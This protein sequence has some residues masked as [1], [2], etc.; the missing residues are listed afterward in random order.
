VH[1]GA[2]VVDADAIIGAKGKHTG[3]WRQP[4]QL[5]L[6]P[7]IERHFDIH[8]GG[9]A[10]ANRE[11]ERAG[12]ADAVQQSMH[13]NGTGLSWWPLNPEGAKKRKLLAFSSAGVER[14]SAG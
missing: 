1:S 5:Q 11:A 10:W 9:I 2:K 8:H 4:G 6:E 12:G 13:D 3:Q 14:Q 7:W